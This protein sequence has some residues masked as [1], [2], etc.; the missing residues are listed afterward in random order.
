MDT[1]ETGLHIGQL[2]LLPVVSDPLWTATRR[3]D[4]LTFARKS[5]MAYVLQLGDGP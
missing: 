5:F 3:P 4:R 1:C 2:A